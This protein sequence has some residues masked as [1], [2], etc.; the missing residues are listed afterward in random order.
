MNNLERAPHINENKVDLFCALENILQSA[1]NWVSTLEISHTPEEMSGEYS[2]LNNA[3][4]VYAKAVG[5]SI[6]R[7]I[8]I[9]MSVQ[10]IFHAKKS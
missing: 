7:D 6:S 5:L 10:D 1:E 8:L 4:I 2:R 9:K 3:K